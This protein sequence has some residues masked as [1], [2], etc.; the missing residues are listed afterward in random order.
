MR[1][2]DFH[3]H[4]TF[5]DG[6]MTIS[7]L[8]D[9]YGKRK[10]GVLAITDH[11]CESLTFL[12]QAARFLNKSLNK[13]TFPKYLEEI[14]K[15]RKRAFKKYGM[16]LI[17]G[18]EITKNSFSHRDSA[19][20]LCLNIDKFIDPDQSIE[21][22]CIDSRKNGGINIAAHPVS[23]GKIEHQTY[24]LWN[25]RE[26]LKSYFDAWE[27]AS[28]PILFTEVLKSNLPKIA[29]SD[30]HVPNQVNSW[31]TIVYSDTDCENVL[32]S[33]RKQNLDFYFYKESKY[34]QRTGFKN[35][36]T[37]GVKELFEPRPVFT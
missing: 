26:K 6:Q 10:F 1:L 21:E 9:F 36:K 13:K 18:V 11:L 15:Q 14:D 7:E 8:V 28:G 4:S 27:V 25:H 20:I 23:T 17:S 37:N 24:H 32:D 22:V 3:V 31:K 33:V 34:E 29:N 16:T 2:C 35:F 5:S 19:H 30:L 12:G